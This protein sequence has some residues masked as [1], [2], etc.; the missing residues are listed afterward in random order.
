MAEVRKCDCCGAI[1]TAD[2]IEYLCPS[3]LERLKWEPTYQERR[4]E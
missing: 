1:F 3:C 4:G 2:Y